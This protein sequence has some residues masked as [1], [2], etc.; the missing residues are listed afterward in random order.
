MNEVYSTCGNPCKQMTCQ[1]RISDV[2]FQP[3]TTECQPGC[4]CKQ[5]YIRQEKATDP[6]V[7]DC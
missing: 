1:D 7:M 4:V 6:C 3:C 2:N 5:D